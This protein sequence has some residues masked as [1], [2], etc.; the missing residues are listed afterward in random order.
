MAENKN[1][2]KEP[3]LLKMVAEDTASSIK[4]D[5]KEH[6]TNWLYSVL[7][8]GLDLLGNNVK[9]GVSNYIYPKGNAPKE[10][11]RS[12][13]G[14]DDAY[15]NYGSYSTLRQD[16][17]TLSRQSATDIRLVTAA[18]EEKADVMI[19]N[20]INKI[21]NS[22]INACR[23]G[24]LYEMATPKISTSMMDWKYGW[25]DRDKGLFDKRIITTGPHAGE[26]MIIVP[27]P[28]LL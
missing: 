19:A 13:Y 6:I 28:H 24:D 10:I 26:Y 23:V 7:M 21:D 27:K 16:S 1:E 9:K 22:S 11:G 5:A 4:K 20:I 2:E 3:N 17:R 12:G 14:S 8:D 15:H 18:T 25:I